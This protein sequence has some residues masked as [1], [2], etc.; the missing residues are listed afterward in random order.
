MEFLSSQTFFVRI[1][2][3]YLSDFFE[4]FLRVVQILREKFMAIVQNFLEDIPNFFH[5]IALVRLLPWLLY[6]NTIVLE[7]VKLAGK[8]TL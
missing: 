8:S 3:N 1:L 4:K 7:L 2:R 5:D 6:C